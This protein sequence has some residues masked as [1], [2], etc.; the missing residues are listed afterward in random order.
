VRYSELAGKEIINVDEGV[1]MGL[2]DDADMVIDTETGRIVSLLMP[3]PS[4]PRFFSRQRWV[5][6]PWSG[7]KKIG[8]DL[9]IIDMSEAEE[10]K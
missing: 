10:G 9:L 8:V 3:L 1:R 4:G 2:V 5:T 7:I 6:L